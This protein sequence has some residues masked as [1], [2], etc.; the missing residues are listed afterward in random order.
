MG[1]LNPKQGNYGKQSI[2]YPCVCRQGSNR[3]L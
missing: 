3:Q 2:V 1:L